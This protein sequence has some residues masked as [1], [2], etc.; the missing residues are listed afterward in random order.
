MKP[1]FT[2]SRLITWRESQPPD[3]S[4]EIDLPIREVT[5]HPCSPR[6]CPRQ[7]TPSLPQPPDKSSAP[8]LD[9]SAPQKKLS[10]HL[11]PIGVWWERLKTIP[12]SL[13]W[14][15]P[16]TLQISE[17]KEPICLGQLQGTWH[18][19]GKSRAHSFLLCL[20]LLQNG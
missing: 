17:T 16:R 12:H 4:A 8:P 13:L 19:R 6:I 1:T 7:S 2:Y 20:S 14:P 18:R 5:N 9:S 11:L 3:M 15:F 10:T